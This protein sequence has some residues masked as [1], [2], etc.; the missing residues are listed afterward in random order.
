M[1]P[2]LVPQL[3]RIAHRAA[4]YG[5]PPA[6][7]TLLL[8]EWER[9]VI[10]ARAAGDHAAYSIKEVVK[11]CAAHVWNRV[12]HGQPTVIPLSSVLLL[13]AVAEILFASTDGDDGL[14]NTFEM[15]F[16]LALGSLA[17]LL[18][19]RPQ[20]FH[21]RMLAVV[22]FLVGVTAPLVAPG[23]TVTG[24]S[25]HIVRYGCVAVGFGALGSSAILAVTSRTKV[26]SW[27]WYP[28]RFSAMGA[29]AIG[30]SNS[31]RLGMERDTG[32]AVGTLIAALAGV[33]GVIVVQ[34]F[35]LLSEADANQPPLNSV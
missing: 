21:P 28:L 35:R 5:Q 31:L 1:A 6:E 34:R 22:L 4:T 7:Q 3:I 8:R 10:D 2:F 15:M 26:P 25:G 33:W 17:L 18:V 24:L 16:G 29:L 20:S 12:W 11:S 14:T 19:L 13:G 9:Y 30:L 32:G 23:V 27:W